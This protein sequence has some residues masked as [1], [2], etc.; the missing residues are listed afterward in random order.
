VTESGHVSSP[1]VWKMIFEIKKKFFLWDLGQESSHRKIKLVSQLVG[2]VVE[3]LWLLNLDQPRAVR[4]WRR[5][6]V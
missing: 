6:E 3:L 2:K 4:W 5:R 1:L